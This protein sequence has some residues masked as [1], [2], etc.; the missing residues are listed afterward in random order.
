MTHSKRPQRQHSTQTTQNRS[1]KATNSTRHGDT[2]YEKASE[3]KSEKKHG[4]TQRRMQQEDRYS[5]QRPKAHKD[6]KQHNDTYSK[7]STAHVS[8]QTDMVRINKALADAGV[9]SRRKAEELIVA[10]KVF[11]NG[12]RVT[13]LGHKVSLQDELRVDGHIIKREDSRVYLLMHKPVQTLCTANDPE[14]RTTIF[15]ILP[16]QWQEKRL[17]TVGRL[18]YF[19]EGLLLLTDDG[20]FAQKLAHP[21]YHLPKVYE[22]L[23]RETVSREAI[24]LMQSGMRLQ[25]GEKLAPVQVRILGR[26]ARSTLLELTLHQGINRQIRRMCRDLHLTILQLI[27]V[28]QGPIELD[29]AAGK[30]RELSLK[31]LKALHEAVSVPF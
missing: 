11:V 9:C 6:Y 17:F 4:G 5:S 12:L 25:E 22:V 2:S 21:R 14:G 20:H 31:E 3:R 24:D 19:S 27:R 30:V 16:R 15:D 1:S 13:E 8:E 29:I 23:V 7:P 18:D 28:A 10:G 26:D